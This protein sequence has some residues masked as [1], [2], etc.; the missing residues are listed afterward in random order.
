MF[1]R[2]HPKVISVLQRAEVQLAARVQSISPRKSTEH[3]DYG[4]LQRELGQYEQVDEVCQEVA[5]VLTQWLKIKFCEVP[6]VV[7]DK[8]CEPVLFRLRDATRLLLENGKVPPEV[9]NTQDAVF[10]DLL[11]TCWHTYAERYWR[12]RWRKAQLGE[13]AGAV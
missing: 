11:I 2:L 7:P 12:Q 13:A 8:F 3:V 1:F 5:A 4:A 6:L 10:Q 9:S